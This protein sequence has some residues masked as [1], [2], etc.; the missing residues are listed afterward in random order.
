MTF[1]GGNSMTSIIYPILCGG[2]FFTL[3]LE[4]R[5]SRSG[6]KE[7]LYGSRDGLSEPEML[8]GLIKVM[9]PEFKAPSSDRTFRTNTYDYKLCRSQG[10]NLPFFDTEIRAFDKRVKSDYQTA[11]HQMCHF[12]DQFIEVGSSVKRDEWLVKALLELIDNDQSIEDSDA[13]YVCENG[14]SLSKAA[15]RTVEALC[16]PAFLL[17]IWH[18]IVVNRHD[19]TVGKDTI[20]S[21]CPSNNRNHRV[22]SGSMGES[23][24][25]PICITI[26]VTDEEKPV[27]KEGEASEKYNEP[28]EE[29]TAR[30]FTA[31][32]PR[33]TIINGSVFQQYGTNNKQIIGNFE[34]L[35]INND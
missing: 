23:I 20:N 27:V 30:T 9:Y 29:E 8:A 26:P 34:T 5:K 31:N 28:A 22:Y 4:A 35:I 1:Y 18:F 19:N 14:R 33:Q 17:G 11:L 7:Q 21:W 16:F 10:S 12:I 24:S 3:L 25:R 6:K 15:L 2:T 13:F 32:D